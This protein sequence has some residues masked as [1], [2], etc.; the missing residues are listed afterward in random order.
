MVYERKEQSIQLMPKKA[1][2][3]ANGF[4]NAANGAALQNLL[5]KAAGRAKGTS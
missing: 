4:L 1:N 2:R 3:S 5:T